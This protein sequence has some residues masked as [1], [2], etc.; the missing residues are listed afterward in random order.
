MY[1]YVIIGAGSAGCVLANRLSADARVQVLLL[2]A[3]GSDRGLEVSVPAAFSKLFHGARDW[4]FHAEPEPQLDG[5]ELYIPRGRMI[6]GSSSMNAMIYI[7]GNSADYDGWEADGCT[8]WSYRD[9]LPYFRRAEGQV[10]GGSEFH[11][12]HGPLLVDDV[13]SPNPLSLAFVAAAEAA[14]LG[15][16][17]DFNGAHQSG[18]GHYQVN[19]RNGRRWSVADAYLKPALKRPNLTVRTGVQVTRILFDGKRAV[20]VEYRRGE[21]TEAVLIEHEVLVAAG[22]I[23]SPQLLLLS[24]VGPA[25]DLEALGVPVI[26]NLPGVGRNL[27]DHPY[28]L[29]DY[30]TAGVKTL[31]SAESPLNLARYLI[32]HRGPLT[33]NV[34]EAGGFLR[35]RPELAAPDLQFHFAPALFNNHAL[36]DSG[37]GFAIAPTLVAPRSRGHLRLSVADPLAP[38]AIVTGQLTER[39]DMDVL[40]E[41]VRIA[42]LLASTEPLAGYATSEFLPGT[43]VDS[44][45]AVETF[46]RQRAELLYHP[47]GTCKMGQDRQA[48]VDPELR[49]RGC[50]GLRVVDASIMPV[51]VRGNTNAPTVMIGERAADLLL[52]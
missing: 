34:A 9:V 4:D 29:V 35:T 11:G 48:V 7:R 50:Q 12:E 28:V 52:A 23:Q 14:G 6:G 20:G 15:A 18:F 47:S 44:P 19:Q 8:G 1:D 36:D 21:R 25:T 45:Q 37:D 2:E 22:A 42:R 26:E 10:N 31:F 27:Q 40:V 51:I 43:E 39:H 33:S 32:S 5:R 16:N 46:L 38:P 17:Q 24:G 13:R 49:V 3:G 41:G 30:R